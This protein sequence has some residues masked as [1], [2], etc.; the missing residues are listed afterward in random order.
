MSFYTSL[1]GLRGAQTALSTIANN[2]ANAGTNGFKRSEVAFGDLMPPSSTTPGFG[3]RVKTIAQQ[4]TPGGSTGSTSNLD[5]ALTGPGFL[6]TRGNDGSGQT[7]LTRNGSL[8][9]NTGR[10]LTDSNRNLVQV[11]PANIDGT[12]PTGGL[13]SAR[14]LQLPTRSGDPVA[15]TAVSLSATL[16]AT[17]DK[18]ALRSPYSSGQAYA[19]DP[20][21]PA[22]YN[23]SQQT[24]VVDAAGKP[25]DATLFFTATSSVAAGDASDS[26]DV[27]VLVGGSDATPSPITL[28]FDASGALTSPTGPQAL[29]PVT[30][31]GVAAPLSFSLDFGATRLGG[32][33]FGVK[34]ITQNG[35]APASFTDFAIGRDGLLSA[36][37]ADGSTQVLG[38]LLLANVPDPSGLRQAGDSQWTLA[39]DAGPPSFGSPGDGAFGDLQIGAIERSNVDLTEELVALIAAQRTFQ[40]NAKAIDAANTLT[41]TVINLQN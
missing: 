35:I 18:P 23:F 4:F 12:I 40:A 27:H 9:V 38:R 19:F 1:S 2:V 10:Y 16:P 6:V 29:A 32:I 37:F 26:W 30:P 3:V 11:L 17:A 21:N 39:R 7:F 24:Q 14:A 36:S 25:V 41:Q 13:A 22:S 28:A 15:T 8:S 33:E 31:A 20:A 5:V 34:D